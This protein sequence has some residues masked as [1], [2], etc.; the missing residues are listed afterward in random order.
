MG[1]KFLLEDDRW[2]CIGDRLDGKRFLDEVLQGMPRKERR[3]LRREF[4]A[5]R[6]DLAS[7]FLFR[8]LEEAGFTEN[9]SIRIAQWAWPRECDS[10]SF[11]QTVRFMA[12]E[13]ECDEP[14]DEESMLTAV[15]LWV[16]AN[17]AEPETSESEKIRRI[18][19]GIAVR[20]SPVLAL[21]ASCFEDG[22]FA[23]FVKWHF[24]QMADIS[25]DEGGWSPRFKATT[26]QSR[27]AEADLDRLVGESDEDWAYLWRELRGY[28]LLTDRTTWI[29]TA[30][31]LMEIA[32]KGDG[33]WVTVFESWAESLTS[34]A[35]DFHEILALALLDA[36]LA[37]RRD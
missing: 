37:V 5:T 33:P 32:A 22:P 17:D 34:S 13:T 36:D 3:N 8:S 30:G 26:E 1:P 7:A 16:V 35:E 23:R 24:R 29:A 18:V 28:D 21:W 11:Q 31:R 25:F 15:G 19:R 9:Q 4:A 20:L 12:V 10:S 14:Y 6:N 2:S 27:A